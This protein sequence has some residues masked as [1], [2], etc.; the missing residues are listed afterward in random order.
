MP[1]TP[2]YL[3]AERQRRGWSQ[4]RVATALGTSAETVGRW[5]RGVA[6]PSPYFRERLCHLF[7]C[8]AV[9]FGWV[10]PVASVLPASQPVPVID[11]LLPPPLR[12]RTHLV[13]RDD[14]L[15]LLRHR[16]VSAESL[17]L[18]ALS[19]LPGVGKSALVAELVADTV[20]RHAFPD[21]VLW[22][23][24]GPQGQPLVILSH[25]GHVLGMT[26]AEQ[27][28]LTTVEQWQ[29]RVRTLIGHR[30]LVIVLDDV[31][32]FADGMAC[33][34]GGP[35]CV[36]L[37]TTRSPTLAAALA[38]DSAYAL[39]ALAPLASHAL[40]DQ[41]IPY[42]PAPD[43]VAALVAAAGGLP[44]VLVV[45]GRFLHALQATTDTQRLLPILE[46]LCHP[47]TWEAHLPS[48]F[49]SLAGLTETLAHSLTLSLVTLTPDQRQTWYALG[50]FP[51]QPHAFPEAVA[52][53]IGA[54]PPATLDTLVD[55]GMLDQ[56]A[57]GWYSMHQVLADY[58]RY[59]L[60]QQGQGA[61]VAAR[62]SAWLIAALPTLTED[63]A[64]LD[65]PLLLAGVDYL[66]A[67]GQP[68]AGGAGI[69]RLYPLLGRRGL[70]SIAWSLLTRAYA[71]LPQRTDRDTDD[72][73]ATVCWRLG[74]V[75][76]KQGRYHEAVRYLREAE[77]GQP[78]DALT[79]KIVH[80]QG[81][82]ALVQGNLDTAAGYYRTGLAQARIH[83]DRQEMGDYANNLGMIAVKQGQLVTAHEWFT[84]AMTL[85]RGTPFRDSYCA[86]LANVGILAGMHGDLTQAATFLQEGATLARHLQHRPLLTNFLGNLAR[87]ARLQDDWLT[88]ASAY[89]DAIALAQQMGYPERE[90]EL[91]GNL[92]GVLL[93]QGD[94][95]AAAMAAH[96]GLRLGQDV[97]HSTVESLC[98][99]VLG[100]IAWT[101][102]DRTAAAAYF[103]QA[104]ERVREGED[105]P[106]L[107]EL[108]L[109]WGKFTM[110][111]QR[112]ATAR[113]SYEEVRAM[114]AQFG[115][116][117]WEAQAVFGLAQIAWAQE[118]WDTAQ[119]F[120]IESESLARA[121]TLPL[122]AIIR[123]WL[124]DHDT[125]INEM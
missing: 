80:E 122:Q 89:H 33:L 124:N 64:D 117:P 110:A 49:P 108:L 16:L 121:A 59:Q 87:V 29:T 38:P 55:I 78:S 113:A 25:W 6:M 93:R 2:P 97:S 60:Q 24:L 48:R 8:D 86:V 81:N 18:I 111:T 94:T 62:W 28:R 40:L 118:D 101:R 95:D 61:T 69:V 56:H 114:G 119:L 99:G 98:L 104:L 88:A 83:S 123:Q 85:L 14:W 105:R 42:F 109:A 116:P 51:A 92:A 54:C 70:Y 72:L 102:Q 36:T 44:L 4:T 7:G 30:R 107:V 11:P 103:T 84:E 53:V 75:A 52:L 43:Q 50:V 82:V 100:E 23:E 1:D 76:L 46:Q 3:R 67:Q 17:P 35:Q 39:P 63:A 27:E 65:L 22:A 9:Q 26:A 68:E 96:A 66:L 32:T 74:Q 20:L 45:I 73:A 5:E 47:A 125:K 120:G 13:G 19:G 71:R 77:A 41:W 10:A 12:G 106:L 112:Y 57:P 91:L 31:W 90:G 79:I 34:V 37:L 115:N 58:A 15:L 21:G